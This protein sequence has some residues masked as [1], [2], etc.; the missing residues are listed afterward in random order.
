MFWLSCS[1]NIG[2]SATVFQLFFGSEN[3]SYLQLLLHFNF[4][5]LKMTE[6]ECDGLQTAVAS[7]TNYHQTAAKAVCLWFCRMV[8]VAGFYVESVI[9]HGCTFRDDKTQ[10]SMQSC[11]MVTYVCICTIH[12]LKHKKKGQFKSFCEVFLYTSFHLN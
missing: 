9:C 3:A 11:H 1:H 2:K 7:G 4:D 10:I 5:D 6:G 12:H 8:K